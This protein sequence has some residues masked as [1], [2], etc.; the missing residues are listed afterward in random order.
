MWC[1]IIKD[2]IERVKMMDNESVI[3]LKNRLNNIKYPNILNQVFYY[4]VK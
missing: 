1:M 3:C 4:I 2:M